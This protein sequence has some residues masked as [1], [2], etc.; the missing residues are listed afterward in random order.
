M[1][2]NTLSVR[3]RPYVLNNYKGF[4]AKEKEDNESSQSSRA[5]ENQDNQYEYIQNTPDNRKNIKQEQQL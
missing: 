1:A 4:S 3:P 5:L 2:F